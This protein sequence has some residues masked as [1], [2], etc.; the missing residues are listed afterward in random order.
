MSAI[1]NQVIGRLTSSPWNWY[2]YFVHIYNDIWYAST[3]VTITR[4][5]IWGLLFDQ[6]DQSH[7]KHMHAQCWWFTAIESAVT[8]H[9]W[10]SECSLQTQW[11]NVFYGT[12]QYL[13]YKTLQHLLSD[14]SHVPHVEDSCCIAGES[15]LNPDTWH[16]LVEYCLPLCQIVI[17]RQPLH[18]M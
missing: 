14:H 18:L 15:S 5:K 4:L 17:Q 13:G 12:L 7:H 11:V 1:C 10:H 3:H 8:T 9:H 2:F 16:C 6:H